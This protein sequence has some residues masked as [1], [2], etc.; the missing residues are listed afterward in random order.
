MKSLI[1]NFL[2]SKK[3]QLENLFYQFNKIMINKKIREINKK[4]N[5]LNMQNKIL[6]VFK[7]I[8][9]N[10]SKVKEVLYKLKIKQILLCK[11]KIKKILYKYKIKEILI[12]NKVN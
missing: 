3:N 11:L 12:I 1:T 2:N 9:N 4:V 10:Q 8:L 6:L 7:D 5:L